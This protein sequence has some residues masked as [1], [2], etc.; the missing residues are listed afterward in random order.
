MARALDLDDAQLSKWRD[1][2]ASLPA[3]SMAER[4]QERR[5]KIQAAMK[6]FSTED[7]DASSLGLRQELREKARARIDR[8]VAELTALL[9]LLDAGQLTKL[10][11]V[12]THE[13]SR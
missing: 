13:R 8:R 4:F 7:F 1:A 9:P 10:A 2:T 5:A 12:V 3:P 6:A 11:D